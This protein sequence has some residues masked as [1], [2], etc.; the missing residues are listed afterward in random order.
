MEPLL[1]MEPL[2]T[3]VIALGGI[4][5]GVGAI[6]TAVVTKRLVRTTEDSL[7]EQSQSLHEQNER[8]RITLEYDLLTRLDDRLTTPYYL[9]TIREASK[10]LRDNAFMGDEI[11]EVSS[12]TFALGEVCAFFEDVGGLLRQGV[13]RAETVWD[14][15]GSG[16]QI[17]WLLCKPAIEKERKEWKDPTLYEQFEYLCHIMAELDRKRGIPAP[18]QELLRQTMEAQATINREPPT[19]P[20]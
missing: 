7:A 9:R 13:I 18:T 15:Y 12:M 11:V 1:Q 20:G 4:A 3:L 2:L 5:T 17:F 19:T 16:A 10:Y 14:K 8:A 6:W